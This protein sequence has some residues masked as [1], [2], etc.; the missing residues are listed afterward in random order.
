MGIFAA[1]IREELI[2]KIL[3]PLLELE[4]LALIWARIRR[5]PVIV[6]G[7]IIWKSSLPVLNIWLKRDGH[8][9]TRTICND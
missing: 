1:D 4:E 3:K 9:S 6:Y 5:C 8:F 7:R 2:D